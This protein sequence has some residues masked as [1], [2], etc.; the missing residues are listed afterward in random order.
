MPLEHNSHETNKTNKAMKLSI[1]SY[2]DIRAEMTI[3]P[4]TRIH[5]QEDS[6]LLILE[7]ANIGREEIIACIFVT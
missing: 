4:T 7:I 2:I 1:Q 6:W 5:E 3:P